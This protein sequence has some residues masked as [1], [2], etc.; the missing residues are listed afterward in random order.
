MK[1]R[2]LMILRS[3][4]ALFARY[5]TFSSQDQ[6]YRTLYI[7]LLANSWLIN[8]SQPHLMPATHVIRYLTGSINWGLYYQAIS[9]V[10]LSAFCD[11][12][13]GTCAFSGRSLMEFCVFLSEFPF[14]SFSYQDLILYFSYPYDGVIG[15]SK[16][17]KRSEDFIS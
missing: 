1:E 4:E 10:N 12:D 16:Q 13:Q 17:L 11:A 5:C 3:T 2:S 8:P 15:F 7:I 9:K 14:P 6:P